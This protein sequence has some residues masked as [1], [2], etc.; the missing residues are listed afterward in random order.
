MTIAITVYAHEGGARQFDSLSPSQII[1]IM[2]LFYISQPFA[3][4]ALA[5]GKVSVA[6]LIAR[7]QSPSRWR[8]TLL[9]VL[10][11]LLVAFNIVQAVLLFFQ[12]NQLLV[13][14]DVASTPAA[15][16]IS[17]V[18][19]NANALAGAGMIDPLIICRRGKN[20]RFLKI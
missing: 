2:R 6:C 16:C 9:W 4:A 15:Q 11:S 3:L 5:A 14:W 19:T 17:L 12:C 8:T 7:L 10:M 13:S 18:S 20:S 1:S